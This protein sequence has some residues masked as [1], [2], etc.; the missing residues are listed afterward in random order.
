MT[1]TLIGASSLV[2]LQSNLGAL[3]N[4]SFTADE[5][6]LIDQYAVETKVN[7]WARSSQ[8]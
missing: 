5:L 2:Q 3:K 1:S 7:R 6:D 8:A 4:L